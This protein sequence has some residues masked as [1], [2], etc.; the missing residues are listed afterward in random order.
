MH[1]WWSPRNVTAVV[2]AVAVPAV[3]LYWNLG[4][5]SLL[6][7]GPILALIVVVL[8][9]GTWWIVEAVWEGKHRENLMAFAKLHG[10]EYVEWTT[11]YLTRFRSFPFNQGTYREDLNVLRGTFHGRQCVSYTRQFDLGSNDTDAVVSYDITMVELPVK[12]PTVDIVPE[13][14]FDRMA[15][16]LGGRDID[17]ESAEFNRVWRVKSYDARYAHALLHPRMLHRLNEADA[18]GYAIRFEGRAV[19]MW[20]AERESIGTLAKRLGVLTALA[21]LVPPHVEREYLERE[22]EEERA[23]EALLEAQRVAELDAPLWAR[24]PG[25]LTGGYAK[26]RE[27]RGLADEPELSGPTWATTPGALTSG[28]YTGVEDES[29]KKGAPRLPPGARGH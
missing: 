24:M 19:M 15:K 12:L 10:W 4:L 20:T 8:A 11:E 22:L 17:F 1:R 3:Y 13:G 2:L 23:A 25:A 28:K 29:D 5:I 9:A 26:A 27:A 7:V 14:G 16:L 18:R 21:K 6:G